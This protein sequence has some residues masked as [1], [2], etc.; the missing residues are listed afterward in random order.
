MN[1]SSS[2]QRALRTGIPELDGLVA[3]NS[4]IIVLRTPD[5]RR[6]SWLASNVVARN[7][8]PG[9]KLLYLQWADYHQRYWSIDF[10]GLGEIGKRA[11]TDL[12]ALMDDVLFVRFFSRDNV[13]CEENWKR[14][15]AIPCEFSIVMLDTAN[16][17]FD[18]KQKHECAKPFHYSLYQFVRLCVLKDC[19]G[20]VL[21]SSRKPLHP[22]LGSVSSVIVEFEGRGAQL[23]RIVKHAFHA[24]TVFDASVKPQKTLYRWICLP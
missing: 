16:E 22:F 10:D 20:V 1:P 2:P 6:L 19:L 4:G 8:V 11:G 9:K 5:Q 14:L 15:F 18:A 21:D 13:E 3:I 7:L 17:L 23:A 24:E 12:E